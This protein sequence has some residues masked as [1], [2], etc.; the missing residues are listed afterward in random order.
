LIL[1]LRTESVVR[2]D[3][4]QEIFPEIQPRG[5]R[6]AVERALARLEAGLVET[7]WSDSLVSSQGSR[8]PK[9]LTRQEGMI[10]ERRFRRVEASTQRVYAAF[11]RLGGKRGWP[12]G[13]WAWTVRGVLDR[14][15]GGVGMRRGRRHPTQLRAG[16]AVDFWRVE[17]VQVDHLVRLRA[18]MKVPGRAWLQFEVVDTDGGETELRQTAFFAPKGLWGLLYWYLLY[19]IHGFIFSRMVKNLAAQAESDPSLTPETAS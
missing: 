8:S 16:D 1:G 2:D 12:G 9:V 18:E 14:L 5:Y 11:S 15:V 19:P 3:S 6:E 10:F 7:A 13:N 4:A 17:E